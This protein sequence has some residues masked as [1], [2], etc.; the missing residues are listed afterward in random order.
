VTAH[1]VTAGAVVE[2]PCGCIGQKATAPISADRQFVV[3]APCEAHDPGG[4]V[5]CR[6]DGHLGNLAAGGQHERLDPAA[7]TRSC[8]RSRAVD[9]WPAHD[10]A[11][12]CLKT[13]T[14]LTESYQLC[15]KAFSERDHAHGPTE[16]GTPE[17]RERA[18]R[19]VRDH[20][21]D[22]PSESAIRSVGKQLGCSVEALSRSVRRA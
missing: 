1:E 16:A 20:A 22:H 9:S 18:V 17:L 14:K 10:P 6:G 5:G 15:R 21:A 7:R 4:I 11:H 8:F 3:T 13:G 19:M 12:V 2:L